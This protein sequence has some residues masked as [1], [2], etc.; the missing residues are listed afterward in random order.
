MSSKYYAKPL[1]DLIRALSGLPGIGGKSAQRLAFHILSMSDGDANAIA[2]AIREAKSRMKYCSVCGNLT[3]TD[4]CG[5]C[6][7]RT[8]DRSVICVVESPRDAAAV[9]R[10]GEYRGFY[11]VLHGVLSPMDGIGPD[12]INLRQLLTR[13][14]KDDDA[15]ELILATNP[16]IEGEATAM[17]IAKLIKPAGIRVTRIAHGIPVGGDL[18]YADEITLSKAMEGRREL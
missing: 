7:D 6:A 1:N 18:E 8:R 14:Q 2:D 3:D 16:T 5:I 17:Y 12:D 15:K 10:T 13:L 11:H 4:P 9:E